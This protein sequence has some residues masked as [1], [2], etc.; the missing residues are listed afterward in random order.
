MGVWSKLYTETITPVYCRLCPTPCADSRVPSLLPASLFFVESWHPSVRT[1]A[2]PTPR[3]TVPAARLLLRKKALKERKNRSSSRLLWK[4]GNTSYLIQ[5]QPDTLR[6]GF[7][8]RASLKPKTTDIQT[9]SALS[10]TAYPRLAQAAIPICAKA[11]HLSCKKEPSALKSNACFDPVSHRTRPGAE[12]ITSRPR[13]H[14]VCF[15]QGLT[16]DEV[17]SLQNNS[18]H[19]AIGS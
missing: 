11:L 15:D 18:A 1:G 6:T 10:V 3:H 4:R 17:G 19:S 14:P 8:E 2:W 7:R 5:G 13:E 16:G 12:E 9:R